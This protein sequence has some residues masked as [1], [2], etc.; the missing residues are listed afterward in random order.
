MNTPLQSQ[1]HLNVPDAQPN[2]LPWRGGLAYGLLGFPL[3]FAALPLYVV[4][5]NYYARSFGLSLA[6]VGALMM[7]VRLMDA[8]VDPWLGRA[9][10]ALFAC[11]ARAVLWVGAGAALLQWSGMAGLFFPA[12]TNQTALAVWLVAG[13]LL[14][15][16]AHS[17]LVIAHQ[18]W[19][20]RL[21]GDELL[22]S[23]IVAWREGLG[24]AGVIAASALSV[25]W[26]AYAM[27]AVFGC[28]LLLGWSFWWR[29]PQPLKLSV[30]QRSE[31][32]S[33]WQPLVQPA[34]RRLLAVFVCNGIASAIPA[35]LMLFFAQDR[36]RASE[37]ATA[38]FLVLYFICAAASMPLWL[39]SIRRFGLVWSWLF[40]M[41]LAVLCFAW[42]ASLGSGQ[43]Q[44][45]ALICALTGIALGADL[46]I[47]G[48]LLAKLIEQQGAQGSHDGAY[49][50]WWNLATKL[51]LA[52]AAGA[53][54]PL[55]Q[56]LGY[57]PGSH[58]EQALQ[59]LAWAYALVPCTLKLIAACL[60]YVLLIR[61]ERES[62]FNWRNAS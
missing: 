33:L 23:R 38:V 21:G 48:A 22:R 2:G 45:F 41:L 3:A 53:A 34:F 28:A 26:G 60:L 62:R 51:N 13:L 50:G 20:V 32:A 25:V 46:A 18:A 15:C 29:A 16:I 27:L 56:W 39:R 30:P 17:F 9:S 5:P 10:D 1:S 47:P 61:P 4:L 24:L 58:D 40:G 55:L 14:T 8:I 31:S 59:H 42:T 7:V 54:L 37:Q 36:L 12:M 35:A 52:L 19:G 49:L 6:T 44:A 57:A 43:I 11:S